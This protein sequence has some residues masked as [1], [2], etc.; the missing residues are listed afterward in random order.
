LRQ[1]NGPRNHLDCVLRFQFPGQL[2][3][4]LQP[5]RDQD[6]IDTR[7]CNLARKFRSNSIG[8]SGN[9]GPRTIARLQ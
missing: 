5:A 2:I 3:E 7:R 9:Q 4:K 6:A 8:C 1:V